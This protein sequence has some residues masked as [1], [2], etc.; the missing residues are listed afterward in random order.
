MSCKYEKACEKIMAMEPIAEVAS[1]A[2]TAEW[3]NSDD[4]Y[5]M[6]SESGQNWKLKEI[7]KIIT[8]LTKKDCTISPL[9]P[10]DVCQEEAGKGH[11]ADRGV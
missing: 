5:E 6:G 3:G 2:E 1:S 4:S 7:Q 11:P 10:C 9:C 8:D